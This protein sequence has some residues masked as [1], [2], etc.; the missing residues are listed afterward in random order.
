M[1]TST[2]FHKVGETVVQVT[3][4]SHWFRLRKPF[5]I[6][7]RASIHLTSWDVSMEILLLLENTTEWMNQEQEKKEK[8][9]VVC[10]KE[11]IIVPSSGPA[12]RGDPQK[13]Q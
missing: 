2:P 1:A 11:N 3:V 5:T 12:V 10:V 4:T 13:S 6:C 9:K 8:A 7:I